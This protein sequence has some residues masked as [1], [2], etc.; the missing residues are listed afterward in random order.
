MGEAV[1]YQAEDYAIEIMIVN[2]L[3]ISDHCLHEITLQ[4]LSMVPHKIW[5][6]ELSP[7]WLV[8]SGCHYLF[9]NGVL[10][11]KYLIY[12]PRSGWEKVNLHMKQIPLH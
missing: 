4:L 11:I 7:F 2:F 6:Q 5:H 1:D 8:F 3:R 9:C 10:R 12:Q